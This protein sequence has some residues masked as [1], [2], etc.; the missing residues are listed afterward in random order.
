MYLSSTT[1]S[2]RKEARHSSITKEYIE[3]LYKKSESYLDLLRDGVFDVTMCI[4]DASFE[5]KMGIR[6]KEEIR[7]KEKTVKKVHRRKDGSERAISQISKP[8]G[9][10]FFTKTNDG[11]QVTAKTYEDLIDKLYAI[12]GG[13]L[14]KPD[15]SVAHAWEMYLDDFKRMNPEKGKTIGNMDSEYNRFVDEE[16]ASRDVR[17]LTAPEIELYCRELITKKNLKKKAFLS[18]KTILNCIFNIAMFKG[19]IQFNPAKNIRNKRLIELCD[20]S[21]AARETEDVILSDEEISLVFSE[22]ARRK[23]QSHNKGYYYFDAMIRLHHEIGCRPGELCALKWQDVRDGVEKPTLHIHAQIKEVG[24]D[25]KAEYIPITKNER[26]VSKG[27]RYF[28]LTK[29]MQEILSEM[30]TMQ[31]NAGIHSE[32]I[33]CHRDGTFIDPKSYSRYVHK[34]FTALGIENKTTYV[35]RRGLNQLLDEKGV[36]PTNRAKLLGH[37]VQ[38][39]ITCYTFAS[40]DAVE[41]GRNALETLN[42]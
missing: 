2:I 14:L 30:K 39:N 41:I 10:F 16:F 3:E 19:W 28:P 34:V 36:T 6:K 20:Q 12:Y 26:G 29:K 40:R 23:N 1:N 22:T 5:E 33:F 21:L 11:K 24:M 15:Y 42:M 17:K 7:I 13:D 18:F 31:E 37:T 4:A 35:F 8:E 38:T 32:F 27:G 9:I 25:R